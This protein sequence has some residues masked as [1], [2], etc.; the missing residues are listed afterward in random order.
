MGLDV[1]TGDTSS[2]AVEQHQPRKA[3]EPKNEGPF[4]TLLPA[5]AATPGLV[6]VTSATAI[7]IL[8]GVFGIGETQDDVTF[9][10]QQYY[11]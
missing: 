2:M 3:A 1:Q 10:L 8:Q 5:T 7:R 9:M 11:E 4:P 6:V